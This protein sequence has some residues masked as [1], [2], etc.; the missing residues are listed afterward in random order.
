VQ[1]REFIRPQLKTLP[2]NVKRRDEISRLA[3]RPATLGAL[4]PI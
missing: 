1:Q 3:Q 2:G 4:I